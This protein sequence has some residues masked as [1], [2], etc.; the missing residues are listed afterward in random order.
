ML[1]A[2]FGGTAWAQLEVVPVEEKSFIDIR[3]ADM[4]GQMFRLRMPEY[5]QTSPEAILPD[6]TVWE[7][8]SE[9][10]WLV[11]WNAPQEQ[12]RKLLRDFWGEVHKGKDT[13][14]VQMFIKNPFEVDWPREDYWMFCLKCAFAE[15]FHDANGFRTYV[16]REGEFVNIHTFERDNF[17]PFAMGSCYLNPAKDSEI[18]WRRCDERLMAKVSKNGRWV[19]GIAS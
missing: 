10:V 5:V 15:E 14:D 8:K 19:V 18:Y 4:P 3:S 2:V 1:M 16:H 13:V 17:K 7:K 11:K 9:N 12:K 6:N